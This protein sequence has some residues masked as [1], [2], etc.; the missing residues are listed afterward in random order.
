MRYLLLITAFF[1]PFVYEFATSD[2]FMT[3]LQV[4]SNL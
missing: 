2:I 1:T 3:I 4:N